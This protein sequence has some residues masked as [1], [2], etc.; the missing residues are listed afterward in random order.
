MEAGEV[1][2]AFL[3]YEGAERE[4]EGDVVEG[5]WFGVSGEDGRG[6]GDF[7]GRCHVWCG[8]LAVD[9]LIY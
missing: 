1:G 7:E 6:N 2:V 8:Y 5:V 4:T 3:D 9:E